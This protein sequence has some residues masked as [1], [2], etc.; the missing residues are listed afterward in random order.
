MSSSDKARI[1]PNLVTYAPGD[2]LSTGPD[3]RDN[4][5]FHID[6]LMDLAN[7]VNSRM[8]L[9]IISFYFHPSMKPS[10]ELEDTTWTRGIVFFQN[11]NYDYT[12]I[13]NIL[14]FSRNH[15]FNGFVGLNKSGDPSTLFI[16]WNK[17]I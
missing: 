6:N 3:P 12:E 13:A 15:L 1:S 7:K 2:G 8:V 11:S 16:D 10:V 17:I 9:Y 4:L 14:V 5:K